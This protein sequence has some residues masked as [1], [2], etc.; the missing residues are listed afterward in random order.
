MSSLGIVALTLG[1]LVVGLVSAS[2]V[3]RYNQARGSRRVPALE[4]HVAGLYLTAVVLGPV[5]P[6]LGLLLRAALRRADITDA[7]RTARERADRL[8][9]RRRARGQDGSVT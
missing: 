6:V 4:R 8:A 2:W 3:A 7:R 1:W 5:A 9:A